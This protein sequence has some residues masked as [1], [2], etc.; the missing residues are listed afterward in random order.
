VS[1]PP[2]DLANLNDKRLNQKRG[3]EQIQSSN[4]YAFKLNMDAVRRQ[5][6]LDSR[7]E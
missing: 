7:Y 2:L 3:S 1:V 6:L 5:K 4:K